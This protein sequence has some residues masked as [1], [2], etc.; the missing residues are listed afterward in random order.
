MHVQW[1]S[2]VRAP[3]KSVASSGPEVDTPV[4]LLICC[5]WASH[6]RKKLSIW[7]DFSLQ[8]RRAS[9]STLIWASVVS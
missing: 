7:G 1:L 8:R 2:G 3:V 5:R 9:E 4:L 6:A